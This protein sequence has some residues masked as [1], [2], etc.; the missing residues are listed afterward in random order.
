MWR[1]K[2]KKSFQLTGNVVLWKWLMFSWTYIQQQQQQ[3]QE[4][5]GDWQLLLPEDTT[6]AA[7][8]ASKGFSSVGGHQPPPVFLPAGVANFHLINHPYRVQTLIFSV[9]MSPDV[10]W[11]LIPS[12][13]PKCDC[14]FLSLP[15]FWPLFTFVVIYWDKS[16]LNFSPS[17]WDKTDI[18]TYM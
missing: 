2:G 13:F 9:P 18:Y 4:P 7:W 17:Y 12:V 15:S 14:S 6:Q 16:S 1:E 8:T 3:L 11:V 10:I 5:R